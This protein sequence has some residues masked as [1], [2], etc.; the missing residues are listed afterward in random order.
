MVQK[1]EKLIHEYIKNGSMDLQEMVNDFTNYIYT[2]IQSITK[3]I[4]STEDIEEIISDIFFTIWKNQHKLDVTKQLKPY[5]AGV[6]KNIIKN[7][8]RNI[9]FD[10]YVELE[11]ESMLKS[12]FNIETII[13]SKD[14]FEI[15]SK[16][17]DKNVEEKKIFIMFYS[18]N[19]KIKEISQ[20][21][22]ITE[23]NVNIKLHR[24]RKKIKRALEKRGY[25]YGK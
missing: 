22:N 25:T 17:L 16:E 2:I 1:N 20:Q 7:R 23:G 10:A 24:I 3:D 4:L 8:L 13:E 6:S 12:D 19:M 5:V 15:I 18:Q 11:D 9:K 21:L 14:K